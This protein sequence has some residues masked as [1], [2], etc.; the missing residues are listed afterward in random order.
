ML[1]YAVN[2][3]NLYKANQ[4]NKAEIQRIKLYVGLKNGQC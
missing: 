3:N 4:E 2:S 1:T